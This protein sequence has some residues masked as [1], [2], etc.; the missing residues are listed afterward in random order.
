M[1]NGSCDKGG[2]EVSGGLML[3]EFVDI[4]LV[5]IDP[6]MGTLRDLVGGDFSDDDEDHRQGDET[7]V[8]VDDL[9][10][11]PTRPWGDELE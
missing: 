9:R 1:V 10:T 6:T 3:D 4:P 11:K 7:T 8:D 5:S 2:S